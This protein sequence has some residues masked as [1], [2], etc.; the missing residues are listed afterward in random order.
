MTFEM[1]SIVFKIDRCWKVY[2][3]GAPRVEVEIKE[4]T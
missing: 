4:A 3:N 1:L 2:T